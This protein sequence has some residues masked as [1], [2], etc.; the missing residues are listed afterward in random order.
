[1]T[2]GNQ[3]IGT[4]PDDPFVAGDDAEIEITVYQDDTN[5]SP[6]DL[7]GA[8]V[9]WV[10][11][12]TAG[13]APIIEKDNGSTGGASINSPA[14]DGVF[15]VVLQP[16]DTEDLEG[17][18]YHEAEVVLSAGDESTVTTGHIRVRPSSV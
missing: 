7:T 16:S 10:L 1:M 6:E 12:A 15:T 18:Y 2:R 8:T 3:D 4:D 13:G 14:T 17:V 11:S 5:S 9:K